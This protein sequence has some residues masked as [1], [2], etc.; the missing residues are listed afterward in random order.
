[1]Q[2]KLSNQIKTTVM[3][4]VLFSSRLKHATTE[5][6]MELITLLSELL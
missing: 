5:H 3:L 1:M 6:I 2:I 4:A